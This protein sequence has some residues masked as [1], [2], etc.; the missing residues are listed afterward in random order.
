YTDAV[1]LANEVLENAQ[2]ITWNGE[3][4]TAYGQGSTCIEQVVD[5]YFIKDVVPTEDPNC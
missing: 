3:G 5:D 2:L 1:A 4:H